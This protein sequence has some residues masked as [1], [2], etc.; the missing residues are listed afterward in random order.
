[1]CVPD[2]MLSP[3][4][5]SKSFNVQKTLKYRYYYYPYFIFDEMEADIVKKFT[6]V[7]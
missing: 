6:Q 4:G 1:M 2:A 3:V 5:V 7:A